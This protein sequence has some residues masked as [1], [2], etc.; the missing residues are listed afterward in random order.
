MDWGLKSPELFSIKQLWGYIKH[1]R[2]QEA[3]PTP[4]SLFAA[5]ELQWNLVS[6]E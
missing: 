6:S 1:N 3:F 4:D 5:I 2:K